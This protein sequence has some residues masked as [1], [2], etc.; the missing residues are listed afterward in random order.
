MEMKCSW[1]EC[2]VVEMEV[3]GGEQKVGRGGEG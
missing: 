3:D 1:G 2:M